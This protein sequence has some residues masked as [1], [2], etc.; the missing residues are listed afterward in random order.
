MERIFDPF[1]TTKANGIGL[2]LPISRKL[3]RAHGGNI[4]AEPGDG[5]GATLRLVLPAMRSTDRVA[6]ERPRS[7][8]EGEFPP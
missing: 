7:A 1:F 4:V 3:A 5:G 6:A 2:G 8:T